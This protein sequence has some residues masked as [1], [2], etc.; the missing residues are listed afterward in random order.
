MTDTYYHWSPSSRRKSIE[1]SGLLPHSL[2]TDRLWRPPYVCLATKPSIGWGLSGSMLR[3]KE[4]S[5]WDLWQVDISEQSGYEELFFD[6][7]FEVKEIRVYERIYKRNI[8]YV[9]SR[10]N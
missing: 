2:S 9:G 5:V 1:R 8:W 7:S 3:G 10:T 6:G 4:H